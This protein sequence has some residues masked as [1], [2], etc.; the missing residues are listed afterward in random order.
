MK[1]NVP[2]L[3]QTF[4]GQKISSYALPLR[5]TKERLP[6]IKKKYDP[7]ITRVVVINKLRRLKT[8][9]SMFWFRSW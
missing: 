1:K 4:P 8:Q 5:K 6:I 9:T 2:V 7:I 3:F